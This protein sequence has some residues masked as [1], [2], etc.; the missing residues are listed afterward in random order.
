[1]EM[2]IFVI[3]VTFMVEISATTTG[4]EVVMEPARDLGSASAFTTTSSIWTAECGC[5]KWDLGGI[6]VVSTSGGTLEAAATIEEP[7]LRPDARQQPKLSYSLGEL[8]N[9]LVDLVVDKD[10]VTLWMTS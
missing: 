3:L 6:H 5:C 4:Q 2:L 7:I 1:M 8:C 9:R 10:R